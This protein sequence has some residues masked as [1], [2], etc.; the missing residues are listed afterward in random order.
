MNKSEK[1]ALVNYLRKQVNEHNK[2][3]EEGLLSETQKLN[4]AILT[5]GDLLA[6]AFNIGVNIEFEKK[7]DAMIGDYEIISELSLIFGYGESY[8][9]V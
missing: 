9:V 5:I 8:K 1:R 7:T 6:N 4:E 3:A 2:K